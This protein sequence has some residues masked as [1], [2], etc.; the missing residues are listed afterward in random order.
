MP[1]VN[2][3]W[4]AKLLD[5]VE[6]NLEESPLLLKAQLFELTDIPPDRQKLVVRV[7]FLPTL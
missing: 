3:K 6:V 1:K 7:K 5:N 2:V 4:G